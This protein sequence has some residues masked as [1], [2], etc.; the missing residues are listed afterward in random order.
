MKQPK[1]E[2]EIR[3]IL[4]NAMDLY[5][6]RPEN[7]LAIA[8]YY[9]NG[10]NLLPKENEFAADFA[11]GD[12]INTFLKC[13]GQFHEDFDLFSN[14]VK[15]ASVKEIIEEKIDVFDYF[16]DEYN[17]Q[18]IKVPSR[19]YKYATDHKENLLKKADKLN[20]YEEKI[21]ADL[22]YNS[23][24]ED[25]SLDLIYCNSIGWVENSSEAI[26]HLER[27]LKKGGRMILDV[28][29]VHMKE[30]FFEHRYPIFNSE[31]HDLMNRGRNANS[32]GLKPEREWENVL[33]NLGLE[34]VDKNSMLPGAIAHFWNFGLRPVFPVLN[35]MANSFNKENRSQ[36]KKEWVETWTDML[37]P[38]LLEPQA[39]SK[40][41]TLY[42]VQYVV[43][44]K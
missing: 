5:W 16:D 40:D 22:R 21:V 38:V 36:F 25:E 18:I 15:K 31:W 32:P 12:G 27:K 9:L 29:T 28:P 26:S 35:K 19:K 39:F 20:F 8:S 42:R 44:K 4:K 3:Q 43:Y 14:G 17:P 23:S 24:V 41:E 33:V 13:G 1:T 30:L 34:I 2:L 7:G 10:A 6:L 11:S 37:L